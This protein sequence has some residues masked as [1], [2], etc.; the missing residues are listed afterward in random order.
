MVV[1]FPSGHEFSSYEGVPLMD[2][3]KQPYVER[4]HCEFRQ[5]THDFSNQ[6]ELELNVVFQS[7]RED[8]IQ[9]LV[10]DGAGVSVIPRYSLLQPE[11]DHRPIMDPPLSR[12]VELAIVDDAAV[13]PALDKL[14][15]EAAAYDWPSLKSGES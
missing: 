7:E 3:V 2:I 15:E 13:S 9:S 4:L 12:M 10:R 11:L 14:I 1:A 6:Y 8:W 5:D